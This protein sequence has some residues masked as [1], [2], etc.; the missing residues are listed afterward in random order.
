MSDDWINKPGHADAVKKVADEPGA[1]DHRARGNSR[2]GV[3]K[4]E[5]KD[6]HRQKCDACGFIGR[7]CILQ[8]EP[9]IPD[10]SVAMAEHEGKSNCVEENSA[11]AGVHD[12]FHQNV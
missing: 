12:A 11:K 3:G 5:L 9:V 10:E 7:W 6:P 2:A 4:G 1:A 8:K